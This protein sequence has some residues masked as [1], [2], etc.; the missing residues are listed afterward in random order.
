MWGIRRTGSLLGCPHP[1]LSGLRT[2][3]LAPAVWAGDTALGEMVT[4]D[5]TSPQPW[6]RALGSRSQGSPGSL[7]TLTLVS[8]TPAS[9]D[10]RHICHAFLHP[11]EQF[12]S[13]F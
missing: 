12:E 8:P 7:C 6:S 5:S 9:P 2:Q 3:E 4:Q 13:V 10:H 11:L 1:L